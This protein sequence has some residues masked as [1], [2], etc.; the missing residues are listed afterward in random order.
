MKSAWAFLGCRHTP[1]SARCMPKVA[2]SDPSLSMLQAKNPTLMD[3]TCGFPHLTMVM[4]SCTKVGFGA[5]SM[6][7]DDPESAILGMRHRRVCGDTPRKFQ[8]LSSRK[9]H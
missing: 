1:S 3:R 9:N 6:A 7:G 4:L 2:P 8:P 5:C